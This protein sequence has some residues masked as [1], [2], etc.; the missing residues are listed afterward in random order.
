MIR[1]FAT[2]RVAGRRSP[3]PTVLLLFA[4]LVFP[5]LGGV[6][7]VK[8]IS[9]AFATSSSAVGPGEALVA[10]SG[11]S[12]VYV[13]SGD[14]VSVLDAQTG[15]M[16]HQLPLRLATQSFFIAAHPATNRAF[17]T[18][19]VLQ[20]N[21]ALDYLTV[22]R[23]TD[24]SI[25]W[26]VPVPDI[27]RYFGEYS[28]IAPSADGKYL[29][30]YNYNDR[31]RGTAPVRYWLSA[32]DLSTGNWLPQ[33][34][35]LP[36][37]GAS[38][39][40]VNGSAQVDVLCYDSN[41]VR[42]INTATFASAQTTPVVIA[43]QQ[44]SAGRLPKVATATSRNGNLYVVSENR[45][46]HVLSN[47]GADRILATSAGADRVVPFQPVALDAAGTNL[48]VPSG[49]ADERSRGL[50]SDL[51]V[52]NVAT[53]AVARTLHPSRPYR[54]VTFSSDGTAAF[55]GL[56]G[57]DGKFATSLVRLDLQTGEETQLLQG[58]VGSGLVASP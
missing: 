50:A 6:A 37:C 55:L 14:H 20:G 33:Q 52:I 11:P 49:S 1:S 35:D 30:V 56:V 51:T 48:F 19:A 39:L 16:V 41:D 8:T 40:L 13:M 46:V 3:G 2:I 12:R 34:V 43:Q 45:E 44:R 7:A 53:G 26:Q 27:I 23:T 10:P 54:W 25:E 18:D 24:W 57:D 5:V 15:Q 42:T 32:L 31:T 38:Q 28:G 47:A 22:Y 17:V 4:L 36:G 21:K 58:P 9:H 29:Y